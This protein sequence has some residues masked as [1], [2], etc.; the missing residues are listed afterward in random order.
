[1]R[2]QWRNLLLS[3]TLL[4]A[5]WA[6]KDGPEI[7]QSKFDFI[8]YNVNYFEDSDVVLFIDATTLNAYRSEDAGATWKVV[9]DV[10]D[11]ALMELIMHPFDSKRAYII[12][13][14]TSHWQTK[15]RGKSWQKFSVDSLASI[16]Q[17]QALAFHAGDPDRIIYNAMDCA[18]IFCEE[19]TYYTTNGFEKT[20]RLRLD[21]IG[22]HW[23]KSS[24]EFT[25]GDK[26]TDLRRIMCIV[27]G[28]FS[29]WSKDYRTVISDDYYA[30]SG[31][32]IQ[33]FE[34]ELEPGKL[35][36]GVVNMAVVTN[37]LVVATSAEGTDEM[38]LYIT[39]DTKKWHRA[40]FPK[41]H[42]LAEK[43][44]TMLESTKYSIQIDV[45]TSNN[46]GQSMG[47]FLTSNSNGTYFFRNIEHTN[48]NMQ[49]MVDFEKVTGIQ[50]ISLVNTV[51]NWEEVEKGH[52][53]KK[54]TTQITFDDGWH[55]HGITCEKEPLHLHSV[56]EM[57]NSG[58]I[59]SSPAPG[60]VMG[61]G[62]TGDY[63]K[64]Y[65]D[66]NLYVSDDAG[67]TW[68]KGL[69]GP[70]KYEFGDQG[71]VLLAIPDSG[72]TGEMKY[73]LNHGKE[74][75]KIDLPEKVRPV[76][77][78]TTQDSTSLKFLLEA[79]DPDKPREK[80]FIISLDF[81][82]MHEGQCKEDQL[83]LWHARVDKDGKP[84]CLMGHTQAFQRRKK[85]A[86]CFMK[87]EFK[88]PEVITEDC[89]CTSDDF[90][91]DYNFVRNE[92][93]SE[94]L[95]VEGTALVLPEGACKDPEKDKTFKGSS[96]WRLIPGNTCKRAEGPQKDDPVERECKDTVNPHTPSS[97]KIVATQA[98]LP[99]SSLFPEVYLER[100]DISLDADETVVAHTDEGVFLSSDHG[101]KWTQILK[102]E[103]IV[104]VYPHRFYK[105]V[106]FFLTATEK[107]F[108]S[109]ERGEN[110]R[111]FKAEDPPNLDQLIVMNFHWKHKDWILWVGGR[112]CPGEKCHSVASLSKD[113]GDTWKTLRRYV[114]KCEFIKEERRL[115][116]TPAEKLG[117]D[118]SELDNLIYCEVRK[119]ERKDP[120]D[121]P[122]QLVSSEDFF[123]NEP[124]VHFENL[125]DF[126]TMSEY[127][128][129][130]TRDDAH[131]TLHVNASVDGRTFAGAQFPHEFNF[132]QSG[133]TVLDSSTHSIFLHVTVNQEKD[134]EYGSII[135]SNSNGTSYGLSLAAVDR[136]APGYV[137]FEKTFGLEGLSLANVV[138]NYNDK[139]F[140]KQGKRLKTMITHNDGA[141]WDLI[142]P[143]EKDADGKKFDCKGGIDKC[144]LNVH[145]YTERHHKSHT[146]S[147][148]TAVGLMLVTG[149]V[150]EYLGKEADTF[151]TSDGGI[152]WFAVK[153][154]KYMW[155]YGD[156]GAIIILVK[157]GAPTK[158]VSYST[159]EG[160]TWEDFQFSDE[161]V[162]IEDVTTTPSDNSRNFLLW[163][164]KKGEIHTINI[165]F[166]GLTNTKCELNE[167]DPEKSP[168][169]YLWTPKHPKQDNNCLF[170]HVS[171][172]IRKKTSSKCYN[173]RVIPGLHDIKE[174]CEC[175]RQDYECDFNYERQTDGSCALVPGFSP[176]DHSLICKVETERVEYF[177]PTGYRKL[178]M[179]T[180]QN[181]REF[182]RSEAKP[183]PGKEKEFE[184]KHSASAIGIFF[185]VI[186]PIAA[187]AGAGWWV[188]RNWASKFGQI[189]LGEQSSF[190][191]EAP[192]VKYPVLAVAGV[193]AVGAALPLLI[194]SLWRSVS[195][196]MG[197]GSRGAARFTTRD[198]FA[199]GRGNYAVV[200]DDADELL[201]EESD[202]EVGV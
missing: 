53:D 57:T 13:E 100:T 19:L 10:P 167:K 142:T 193:V 76:Q 163:M 46:R 196:A 18:G 77:L 37:Y 175:T 132:P 34:P 171:Q 200:D 194:S 40:V 82:D 202:E 94:C 195:T 197:G 4:G 98:T 24:K 93:H 80:G 127:I 108:Y 128:V 44:Y 139:D 166:T 143:P 176:P 84:K 32:A 169:Y 153:K 61:I 104:A 15:D 154:G 158:T 33:E 123:T 23:A 20:T 112:D 159:D 95:R 186:I 157:E 70:H 5:A 133:Y 138:S 122:W 66:G 68:I 96:G 55:F 25:T 134:L 91:C 87:S 181:G 47:V 150:G 90:E 74:W 147:S 1:M 97:G 110:I 131:S 52:E 65:K 111:E 165:D 184:K 81:D 168:D 59:F 27:R 26:D 162:T 137:D 148:T 113:R 117:Q 144:S 6:K 14:E 9:E 85:D 170:G 121:N 69:D 29:P 103:N 119:H 71:S 125:V 73:S 107:V 54:V 141:Q 89:P 106:V 135:K 48:R 88:D 191:S 115:Y 2:L 8:P 124:M 45:L 183:C 189:R 38:A 72:P 161:E 50:G 174:N 192:W 30:K 102:D 41:D 75:K 35:V 49:G 105:D 160:A 12:T 3:S 185:A 179:S 17:N 140:K 146:Y 56:T 22:C 198:S 51:S 101:K 116:T 118:D 177:T 136:D 64:P 16:F 129:V 109:V 83:E 155:E 156:Q 42:R 190:D 28:K 172:I 188:W 11:G 39:D 151:M 173:P 149:S 21:T 99:G 180:C 164:K 199:R 201:G 7:K 92:D 43:A 78:T 152:S 67:L 182:D 60:I 58:R 187:A 145:G 79:V 36:K 130:A 31:S 62:N 178:P 126:A 63:L 120:K 114:R 86:D